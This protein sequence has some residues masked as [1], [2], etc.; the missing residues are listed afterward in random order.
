MPEAYF[1]SIIR[2]CQELKEIDLAYVDMPQL[3][4]DDLE[5]LAKNI[6]PNVVKLNL[7]HQDVEDDH[8][9]ILLSRCHKIKILN[10]EFTFVTK[11]LLKTIR[12]YLNLTL[13]ELS[14]DFGIKIRI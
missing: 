4:E 1:Q 8:I 7:S 13:E 11:D 2:C 14:L 10:L 6:S 12:Q 9:K 5:F 3:T